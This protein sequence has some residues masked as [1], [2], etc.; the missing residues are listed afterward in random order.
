MSFHRE[1]LPKIM[2]ETPLE[3]VRAFAQV[4]PPPL[5]FYAALKAPGVSLIAE[6]KKAS[7]SKGLLVPDY[8]PVKAG[9]SVCG[10]RRSRHFR[11]DGRPS[12]SRLIGRFAGCEGKRWAARRRCCAKILC[13]ILTRF[14]KRGRPGRTL[15][16]SSPPFSAT[17]MWPIY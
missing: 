11:A 9:A 7:P 1:N 16:C 15:F 6:C 17:G 2:R 10:G 14:T 4:A 13:F 5:D 8:D 12:L 3:N